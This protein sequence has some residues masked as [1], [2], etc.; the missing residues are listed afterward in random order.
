MLGSSPVVAFVGVSDLGRA[1]QFY[2][3]VLG[4]D[5]RDES[6]Y[7]LVAQTGT[8]VLRITAVDAP[9]RAAYTVLGWQVDDLGPTVDALAARGVRFVRY[10]G[11][12]GIEQDERG[13]W[14]APG[15]AQVAWFLDPD[16]NLLSLTAF[17]Q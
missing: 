12:G 11:M 5:L 4:L 17:S 3:Q 16:Q 15:G 13:I 10:Q 2:G 1:A 8:G 9:V 7:A 6:P 14:S